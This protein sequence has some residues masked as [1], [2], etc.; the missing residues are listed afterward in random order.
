[1][2]VPSRGERDTGRLVECLSALAQGGSNALGARIV[3]L[4][5]GATET[6]VVDP[7]CGPGSVVMMSPASAE[8]A[9]AQPWQKLVETR[10]FVIGHL[11]AGPGAILRYEL[12]RP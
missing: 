9:A 5:P 7:L 8:A 12:R 1:M 11:P 3:T 6:A 4:E 10:R 2:I